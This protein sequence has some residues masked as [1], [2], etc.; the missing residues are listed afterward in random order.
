MSEYT[1]CRNENCYKHKTCYR[2][3]A[4]PERSYQSYAK[5]ICYEQGT[6]KEGVYY[7][8][9]FDSFK[10]LKKGK[11]KNCNRNGRCRKKI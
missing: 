6:P 2:F 4:K 9:A 11:K 1:M 5:F 8:D 7:I 3:T 10:K